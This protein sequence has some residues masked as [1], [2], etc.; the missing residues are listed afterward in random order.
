M[1]LLYSPLDLYV[2]LSFSEAKRITHPLFPHQHLWF[3]FLLCYNGWVSSWITKADVPLLFLVLVSLFVFLS[4]S[5][6]TKPAFLPAVINIR[7]FL[8]NTKT[9]WLSNLIITE[10]V[11]LFLVWF[12]CFEFY[13]TVMSSRLLLFR[14]NIYDLLLLLQYYL[15]SLH[16]LM[17]PFSSLLNLVRLCF[18]ST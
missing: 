8:W 4:Y 11:F 16:I 2:F 9:I 5:R 13:L 7:L 18:S 10:H 15:T 6:V 3:I 17:T 1:F 14:T 12:S